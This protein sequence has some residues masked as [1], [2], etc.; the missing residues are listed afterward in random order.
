[1][2]TPSSLHSN[3]FPNPTIHDATR[4]SS[5]FKY[6]V[7]STPKHRFSTGIKDAHGNLQQ[8]VQWDIDQYIPKGDSI[9]TQQTSQSWSTS[10]KTSCPVPH[11]HKNKNKQSATTTTRN[12]WRKFRDGDRNYNRVRK[13]HLLIYLLRKCKS[14][15]AYNAL[16]RKL[17]IRRKEAMAKKKNESG[18]HDSNRCHDSYTHDSKEQSTVASYA[19]IEST[20]AFTVSNNILPNSALRRQGTTESNCMTTN[21]SRHDENAIMNKKNW[22][23]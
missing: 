1:M 4:R 20:S 2:S 23:S 19:S 7:Q 10:L 11:H 3:S 14:N 5:E 15:E 21:S 6:L 12:D 22:C 16:V 18:Q 8:A 9:E 13:V 17:L